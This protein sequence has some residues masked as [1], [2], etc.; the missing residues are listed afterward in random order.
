MGV[1]ALD[2]AKYILKRQSVS[3]NWK[4]ITNLKLQKILYYVQGYHLAFFN[5]PL[6][7]EKISALQY[8]P[9]VKKV[10]QK[11]NSYWPNIIDEQYSDFNVYSLGLSEEQ[12]KLIH[13]ISDYYGRFSAFQLVDMTHNESPWIRVS[14]GGLKIGWDVEI[15]HNQ[16]FSFFKKQLS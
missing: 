9:V 15:S 2:V 7:C 10:Y 11:Y 14:E 8:W 16:L 13:S 1:S 5:T 6:F 12:I 3:K 4:C